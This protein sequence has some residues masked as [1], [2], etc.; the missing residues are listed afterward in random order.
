MAS[1]HDSGAAEIERPEPGHL[2]C[3][4]CPRVARGHAIGWRAY[5]TDDDDVAIY[6][7]ACAARAFGEH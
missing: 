3:S 2:T 6:C 1:L 7:P 5:L 4:A